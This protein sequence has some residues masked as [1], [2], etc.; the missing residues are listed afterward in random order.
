MRS[1]LK[2]VY[3]KIF[4]SALNCPSC[5]ARKLLIRSLLFWVHSLP[6][7]RHLWAVLQGPRAA[8]TGETPTRDLG[9]THLCWLGAGCIPGPSAQHCSQTHAQQ[10][11]TLEVPLSRV[12]QAT[13]PRPQWKETQKGLLSHTGPF[14]PKTVLGHVPCTFHVLQLWLWSKTWS[15]PYSSQ[16]NFRAVI[17]VASSYALLMRQF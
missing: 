6:S 2:I 8:F 5:E 3:L 10:E 17:S 7:L 11:L 13:C 16:G 15:L 9:S 14:P 1:H 4:S 12:T